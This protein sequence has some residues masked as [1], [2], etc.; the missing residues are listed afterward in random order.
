LTQRV[1]NRRSKERGF[2]YE[3]RLKGTEIRSAINKRRKIEF[4]I[5]VVVLCF[6]NMK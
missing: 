4:S 2:R 1:T 3:L 5:V 6:E